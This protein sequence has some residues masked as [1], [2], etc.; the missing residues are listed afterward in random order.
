MLNRTVLASVIG[1]SLVAGCSEAAESGDTR[2]A[3]AARVEEAFAAG[4]ADERAERILSLYH[5][6][7]VD[8]WTGRLVEQAAGL[9]ART[10]DPAVTFEP[11]DPDATFLSVLDGYEYY[12]NLPPEGYV[13]LTRPDAEP[14]N[15]MR[16]PFARR[17]DG[18]HV[19]PS[20]QRRLVNP[21]A[22]ADRQLQ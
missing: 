12:P 10:A 19:F 11:P 7:G 1:L 20:L 15:E 18:F 21:D 16:I 17:G 5:R 3:F 2:E 22:E 14:G 9:L 4:D 13:V 8:E 6:D